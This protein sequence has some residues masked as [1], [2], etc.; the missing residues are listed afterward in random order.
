MRIFRLSAA[1]A[2]L[3]LALATIPSVAQAQ[4][5]GLEDMIGARA[6]QAESELQR[7]GYRNVGGEKGDDR[8]YAYWWND[9]HHQCVSIA[10][11]NGRYQS[12]TLTSAPDCRQEAGRD[13]RG[14]YRSDRRNHTGGGSVAPDDLSRVC[15]S[16]ASGA[17]DRRPSEVTA[18]AP[19]MQRNG[20][21]VQGWYDRRDS[22]KG[23][24]F[25]NCRFDLD[26]RFLGVN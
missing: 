23:T 17:F 2:A 9:E 7:R 3:G 12:V 10:T 5:T 14:S 6:G 13:Q 25:F 1:G 19:I 22:S 21:L 16:E 20:Y 8:S 15:R 18:N 4:R 24:K 11:M 26:G